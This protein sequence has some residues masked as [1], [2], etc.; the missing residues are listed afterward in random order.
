MTLAAAAIV[1]AILVLVTGQWW[2][3]FIP[4]VIHGIG[5]T[6]VTR[7]VFKAIGERDKPDPVTQARLD[8]EGERTATS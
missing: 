7:G 2:T 1:A 3:L 8:D 4:V 6:L 5:S